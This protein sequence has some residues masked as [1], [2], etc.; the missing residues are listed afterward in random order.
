M[1]I[2]YVED[3]ADSV[4]VF[5]QKF[6]RDG[7]RCDVFRNAED[8]LP[9]ILNENYDALVIDICLP[10]LS[11]VELLSKLRANQLF[12]P[13]VLITAFNSL[14][15]AK[16]ALN[17]SA[18]YLLEKPF[19]YKNLK[20]VIEKV[21]QDPSPLQLHAERQLKRFALT[22]R[23]QEIGNL[24]LKGFSNPEIAGV[25]KLSEKTVK[26]YVGQIFQKSNANTRSEFFSLIFPV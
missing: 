8:A 20:Q 19:A 26:Q 13:C 5:S 3:D 1:K 21:T 22:P 14:P 9:R 17:A 7:Y 18:N 10:G 6:R 15:L 24:L 2:A 11:G 12:T 16:Q 23:E 25:L 4:T